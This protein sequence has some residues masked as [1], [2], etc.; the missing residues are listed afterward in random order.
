MPE[1]WTTSASAVRE[2]IHSVMASDLRV[3]LTEYI[4]EGSFQP[5]KY[6]MCQPLVELL[7]FFTR[8]VSPL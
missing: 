7:S 5:T 1:P 4:Q 8:P 3:V 6:M 2:S